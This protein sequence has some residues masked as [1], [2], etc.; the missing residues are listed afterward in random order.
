MNLLIE[1]NIIRLIYIMNGRPIETSEI[2]STNK[3]KTLN[4]LRQNAPLCITNP[5][6]ISLRHISIVNTL[7]KK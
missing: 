2:M 7:V 4:E 3:S 5:Y 1:Y 6:D